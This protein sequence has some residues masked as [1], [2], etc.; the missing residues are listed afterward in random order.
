MR[1]TTL[2]L[3]PWHSSAAREYRHLGR[4]VVLHM[5]QEVR[6]THSCEVGSHRSSQLAAR[7]LAQR[8]SPFK[9]SR[10]MAPRGHSQLLVDLLVIHRLG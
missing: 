8:S 6:L 1:S 9:G 2:I 7:G 3:Q 4:I 5:I 10:A